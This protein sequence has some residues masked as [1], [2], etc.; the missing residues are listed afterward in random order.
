MFKETKSRET[1]Q[2]GGRDE[3]A[4]MSTEADLWKLSGNRLDGIPNA[5]VVIPAE[6]GEPVG[7]GQFARVFWI[8][9]RPGT[10]LISSDFVM[11][12][13]RVAAQAV[14]K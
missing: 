6:N 14:L 13:N 5:L 7:K 9:A 4:I 2:G 12:L 8:L 10:T 1:H 3:I 11:R